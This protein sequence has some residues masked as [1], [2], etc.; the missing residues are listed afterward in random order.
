MA[1]GK[2][3]QLQQAQVLGGFVLNGVQYNPNDIIEADPKIIKS[4]GTSVDS[5]R[6]AVDY[7]LKQ[8]DHVIK[9]HE[10]IE[11]EQAPENDP[12]AGKGTGTGTGTGI[13]DNPQ[14]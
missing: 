7:C 14:K 11:P 1:K 13:G 6:E 9:K 3:E 4:L 8:K 5:S 10:Y 12:D 2:S